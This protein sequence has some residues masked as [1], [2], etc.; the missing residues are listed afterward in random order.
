MT[1]TQYDSSKTQISLPTSRV[2]LGVVLGDWYNVVTGYMN[3]NFGHCNST[4]NNLFP[5]LWLYNGNTEFEIAVCSDGEMTYRTIGI[6]DFK[7]VQNEWHKLKYIQDNAVARV[8]IDDV[9]VLEE[10]T[11]ALYTY[12]NVDIFSSHSV[13]YSNSHSVNYPAANGTIKNLF[14]CT[15]SFVPTNIPS[16]ITQSCAIFYN[17][18]KSGNDS[19]TSTTIP[20]TV[21]ENTS[22]NISLGNNQLRPDLDNDIECVYVES[23]CMLSVYDHENQS[24]NSYNS[25]YKSGYHT[26]NANLDSYSC[27]C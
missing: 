8:T 22:G 19:C 25:P 21:A 4:V 6:Y 26:V 10:A 15:L 5:G 13:D 14:F 27:T 7:I 20:L 12:D 9:T 3:N 16:N 24:G 2:V 1:H 11:A 18:W 23:G 17:G